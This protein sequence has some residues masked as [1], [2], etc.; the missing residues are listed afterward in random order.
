MSTVVL[1][2]QARP[3]DIPAV[4]EAV[5]SLI[6]EL[7]GGTPPPLAGAA[8]VCERLIDGRQPGVALVARAS[9]DSGEVIGFLGATWLFTLRA[10]GEIGVI[11]ELWTS[12]HAR[13][14]GVGAALIDALSARARDR[15]ITLL[16]VGLPSPD[17]PEFAATERFYARVGFIPLG[18][19]L[20]KRLTRE[21]AGGARTV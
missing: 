19:R 2:E 9:E 17:F 18:S 6:G 3:A 7:S 12:S 5:R 16:E 21:P 15:G 10:G 11:Q 13:G 20:R 14:Q 8:D 1:V 4:V